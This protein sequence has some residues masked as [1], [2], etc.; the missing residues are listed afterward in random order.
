MRRHPCGVVLAGLGESPR[1]ARRLR[2][3]RGDAVWDLSGNPRH[4]VR[5]LHAANAELGARGT[6]RRSVRDK[7]WTST[8]Q[9]PAA[10][11]MGRDLA[12][13]ALGR[14]PGQATLAT[15][16][17]SSLSPSSS[18]T[19][20]PMTSTTCRTFVAGPAGIRLGAMTTIC[21]ALTTRQQGT[22]STRG[23]PGRVPVVAE[24]TRGLRLVAGHPIAAMR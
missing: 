21:T 15:P 8:S 14:G 10:V 9:P 7:L 11:L 20:T 13:W 5:S 17:D 24:M 4:R 19:P 22:R 18:P 6:V 1:P 3:R 23:R 12:L 16:S 2:N